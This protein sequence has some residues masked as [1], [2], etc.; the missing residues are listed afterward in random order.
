M[1]LIAQRSPAKE[2]VL[3]VERVVVDEPVAA[4]PRETRTY[5]GVVYEKGDDGQWHRQ[6]K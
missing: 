5:K 2:P 1:R 4:A 6:Q 3:V